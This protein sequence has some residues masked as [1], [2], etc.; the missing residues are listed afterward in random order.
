MSIHVP[1]NGR[2]Q[3]RGS[4]GGSRLLHYW[5]LCFFILQFLAKQFIFYFN[6]FYSFVGGQA[7]LSGVSG[8]FSA[9]GASRRRVVGARAAIWHHYMCPDPSPLRRGVGDGAVMVLSAKVLWQKLQ[10]VH[11]T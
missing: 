9:L 4:A 5:L 1:C 10:K 3:R 6:I 7:A 2:G 8:S 11:F